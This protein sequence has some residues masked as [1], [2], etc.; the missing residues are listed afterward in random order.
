MDQ[1][2][3]NSELKIMESCESPGSIFNGRPIKI[4]DSSHMSL[5][6]GASYDVSP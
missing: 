3:A 2:V 5:K 1:K 4:L 6:N